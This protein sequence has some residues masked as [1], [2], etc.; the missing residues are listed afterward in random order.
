MQSWWLLKGRERISLEGYGVWRVR[1]TFD[2]VSQ[3]NRMNVYD[4]IM[5]IIM[6]VCVCVNEHIIYKIK[7]I[8]RDNESLNTGEI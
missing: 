3:Y 8:Y 2:P 4:Y 1:K 6:F 7:R 5:Y